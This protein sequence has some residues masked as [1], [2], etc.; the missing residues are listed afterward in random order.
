LRPCALTIHE[1][2]C[3]KQK[4]I[5]KS[6]ERRKREHSIDEIIVKLTHRQLKRFNIACVICSWNE[7]HCDDHH[8][9]P[10]S[11]GG[12][13]Q[14]NNIVIICPNCHRVIHESNK[15]SVSFLQERSIAKL[16]DQWP[17]FKEF[18]LKRQDKLNEKHKKL[19]LPQFIS[20]D[21]QIKIVK[22]QDSNIDFTK[23]GWVGEVA[24]LLDIRPQKVNKWIRKYMP[25]FYE[26]HCFKRSDASNIA[27]VVKTNLLQNYKQR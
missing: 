10:L 12:L 20:K 1:K 25:I 2:F 11:E 13:N 9:I 23:F 19:K 21:A 26:Q 5:K 24:R 14:L 7:A 3:G 18:Y 4:H 27:A 8:I 15:Y 16:F 6:Q 17:N 22:V